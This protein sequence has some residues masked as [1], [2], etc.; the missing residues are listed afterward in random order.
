MSPATKTLDRNRR[1]GRPQE[2]PTEGPTS[3][4]VRE[5]VFERRSGWRVI[6]LG[7]LWR[8]REL[9]FFLSWR[10]VKVRYKQTLLG[11]SWAILQ[12]LMMMMAFTVFFSRMAGM[13]S[14]GV[15]YPLFALAGLLPWLFL[16]SA[17]AGAANS[18]VGSE[19]LITKVYFPRLLFPC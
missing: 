11:A 2:E 7:E 18:V 16:A 10:D 3:P 5:L 6:D 14:G 19:R 1:L 8:Y 15:P 4:Q 17:M 12:P 9:L 13:T